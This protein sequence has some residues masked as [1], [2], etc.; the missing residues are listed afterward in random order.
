MPIM[1][2]IINESTG[3]KK[4]SVDIQTAS[5]HKNATKFA[6]RI[7]QV[8]DITVK[9]NT[10]TTCSI[11]KPTVI[12]IVGQHVTHHDNASHSAKYEHGS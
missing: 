8:T 3:E 6:H 5:E 7:F 10:V 12:H 1:C 4:K 11:K 2:S 9:T